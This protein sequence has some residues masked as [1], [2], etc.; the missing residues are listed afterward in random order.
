MN[1]NS[2]A[3]RSKWMA[4]QSISATVVSATIHRLVQVGV[5]QALRGRLQV[6]NSTFNQNRAY[7]GGA[8]DV[9][10]AEATLTHLTMA[11]KPIQ[12]WGR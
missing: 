9:N 6:W 12:L 7:R 1:P 2:A 10:G 4:A 5:I 3:A 11:E 8:I